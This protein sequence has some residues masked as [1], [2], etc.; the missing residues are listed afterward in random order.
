MEIK[1][2]EELENKQEK[3]KRYIKLEEFDWG[4]R[5]ISCD[6]HGGKIGE[7]IEILNDKSLLICSDIDKEAIKKIVNYNNLE[8]RQGDDD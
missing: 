7:I 4:V 6:K 5:V 8:I 2:F 1:I 3:E